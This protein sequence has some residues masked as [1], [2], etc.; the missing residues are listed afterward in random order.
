MGAQGYGIKQNIFLQDNNSA[1]KINPARIRELGTTV[2]LI[3]L[4]YLL[5]IGLKPTKYQIYTAA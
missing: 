1:I 5:R 4:I 2:T 3:Y